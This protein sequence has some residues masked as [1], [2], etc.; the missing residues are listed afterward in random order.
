MCRARRPV[1]KTCVKSDVVAVPGDI[2][3]LY[4]FLC[5]VEC[6]NRGRTDAVWELLRGLTSS[7]PA[8]QT[9]ARILLNGC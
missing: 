9:V 5:G 3:P 6:R 8:T 2:D 1:T 7:D 4:L